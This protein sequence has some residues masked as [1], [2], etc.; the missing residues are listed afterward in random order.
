MK[1]LMY[2]FVSFAMLSERKI[3]CMLIYLFIYFDSWIGEDFLCQILLKLSGNLKYY[4]NL[5]HIFS[6]F[7]PQ[8]ANL[9]SIRRQHFR[10]RMHFST[11]ARR[12]SS[13][14]RYNVQI[15]P[16]FFFSCFAPFKWSLVSWRWLEYLDL[17]GCFISFAIIEC[18]TDDEQVVAMIDLNDM[19]L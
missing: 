15:I 4:W 17:S 11:L 7:Q 5:K 14:S 3:I 8:I 1:S 6:C 18:F 13:N 10:Q 19:T 16:R 2:S 12:I 9:R